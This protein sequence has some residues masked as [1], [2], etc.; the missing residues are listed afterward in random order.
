MNGEHSAHEDIYDVREALA[1][2]SQRQSLPD[3]MAACNRKAETAESDCCDDDC[4]DCD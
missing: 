3:V 4:I 2:D 1:K